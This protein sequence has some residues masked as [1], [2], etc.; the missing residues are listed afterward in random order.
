MNKSTFLTYFPICMVRLT[1]LS[2]RVTV[3]VALEIVHMNTDVC[4]SHTVLRYYIEYRH[5][6]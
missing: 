5:T 4:M 2:T 3:I 6:I 1:I